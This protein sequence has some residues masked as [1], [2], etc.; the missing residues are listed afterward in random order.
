MDDQL[1]PILDRAGIADDELH[2]THLEAV[3][4]AV[5]GIQPDEFF[6]AYAAAPAVQWSKGGIRP[7]T[8]LELHDEDWSISL[9]VPGNRE[10]LRTVVVAGALIEALDRPERIV[11]LVP[12][13]A[14]VVNLAAVEATTT[15]L[16]FV[17]VRVP[18]PELP[19]ALADTV[20]PLDFADLVAAIAEAPESFTLASGT[21]VT[22]RPD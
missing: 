7:P 10:H 3:T 4:R 19:D 17:L 15:G 13:L 6:P 2:R 14:A 12:L 11:W 8:Y 16:R 22:F 1:Q 20:N 18:D 21:T 5:S 9:R